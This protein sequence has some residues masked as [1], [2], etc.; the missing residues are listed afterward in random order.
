MEEDKNIKE[1]KNIK[2]DKN[3]KTPSKNNKSKG[4][5]DTSEKDRKITLIFVGFLIILL[6]GVIYVAFLSSGITFDSSQT[7]TATVVQDKTTA[8]GSSKTVKVTCDIEANPNEVDQKQVQESVQTIVDEY[9]YE[10]LTGDNAMDNLKN[11][12][13]TELQKHVGFENVTSIY[14]AE[15]DTNYSG[16]KEGGYAK[17][18]EQRNE[19]MKGLFK[20]MK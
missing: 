3:V 7:Y 20:N 18:Q 15:Y 19:N 9:T 16:K 2:E 12:I 13:M 1:E 5:S 8:D 6:L 11:S 17:G 4:K 14:L 10:E